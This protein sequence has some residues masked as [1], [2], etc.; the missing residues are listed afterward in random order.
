[1]RRTEFKDFLD[2]Q[3]GRTEG[4]VLKDFE[5]IG[6][7][8]IKRY[9]N[10]LKLEADFDEILI[11]FKNKTYLKSYGTYDFDNSSI[12]VEEHKL[13]HELLQ[14]WGWLDE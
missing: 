6:Y 1:M 11:N 13:L 7:T 12:T 9:K 10:E 8:A 3:F 4:Q 5:K 2:K 14:I